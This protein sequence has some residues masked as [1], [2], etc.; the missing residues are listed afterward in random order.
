MGRAL[1]Q[2]LVEG[3][4]VV[5]LKTAPNDDEWNEHVRE[6][7]AWAAETRGALVITQGTGPTS[8]QRSVLAKEPR[9]LAQPTAVVSSSPFT[10]GIITAI[11]WMGG[12]PRAFAPK[13]LALAFDY[14]NIPLSSRRRIQD[15]VH[16]MRSR[17]EKD[18]PKVASQ[19]G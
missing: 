14:L 18:E 13:D 11:S 15:E 8:K 3:F 10:R 4:R 2:S 19:A 7:A 6:A 9:V 1:L 12:K 16:L 5:V 17:L